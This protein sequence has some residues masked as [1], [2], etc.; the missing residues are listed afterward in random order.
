MAFQASKQPIGM[1]R[2]QTGTL[3]AAAGSVNLYYSDSLMLVMVREK[4]VAPYQA[5]KGLMGSV[6]IYIQ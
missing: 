2:K 3:L 5:I 4:D 6:P 1:P